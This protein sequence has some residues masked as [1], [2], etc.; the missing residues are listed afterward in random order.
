MSEKKIKEITA[1]TKQLDENLPAEL[2]KKM[3]YYG[4]LLELYGI[5]QAQTTE[6]WKKAEATRKTVLGHFKTYGA[7]LEGVDEPKTAVDKEAQAEVAAK[8]YRQREAEA[9]GMALHWKARREALYEQ[10]QIMK[11]IYEHHVNVNNHGGV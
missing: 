10:I 11:K 1:K 9:E 7:E 3:H 2:L 8:D 4:Q 5:K 6:E